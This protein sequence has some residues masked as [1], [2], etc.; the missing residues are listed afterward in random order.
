[1][2]KKRRSPEIPWFG[3]FEKHTHTKIGV[4]QA[5][6]GAGVLNCVPEDPLWNLDSWKITLPHSNGMGATSFATRPSYFLLQSNTL[7]ISP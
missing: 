4:S 7:N 3:L 2:W 5:E 6:Q 1:M